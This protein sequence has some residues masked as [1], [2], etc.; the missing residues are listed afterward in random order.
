MRE[1]RGGG[2]FTAVRQPFHPGIVGYVQLDPVCMS[3][4]GRHRERQK[5]SRARTVITDAWTVEGR[6]ADRGERS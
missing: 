3:Q 1:Y 2:V 5:E 4:E 6:R